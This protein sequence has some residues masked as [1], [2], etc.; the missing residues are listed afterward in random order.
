MTSAQHDTTA[1]YRRRICR[2]IDFL[3]AHLDEAPS[4]AQIAK[5]APF[6]SFHFQRLFR[7]MLGE[8]VGEF[9]RRLRLEKAA[10][11]LLFSPGDDITSIAIDLGFSSSQN[12]A[13][14]F[15]KHFDVS[16]TEY[17]SQQQILSKETGEPNWTDVSSTMVG[18]V[19][20]VRLPE[21]RVVYIRHF[22][23]YNDAG[24][25][26][27]FESLTR[28][29]KQRGLDEWTH[30]LGVPW[31]DLD[32]SSEERCRF[33]ACLTVGEQTHVGPQINHQVLPAGQYATYHCEITN[34]DFELPWTR[35]MR[36]W[37]PGSGYQPA[38]GPRLEFYH[39]DGSD[40][41]QG[42]WDLEVALPVETL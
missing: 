19:S 36:D 3:N 7:A 4:V 34:H 21:R 8:S 33:D 31:D 2:A 5:A 40:D 6:S 17:R 35:L 11:R 13:K 38:D 16:P 23:S 42:R 37:L 25:Q 22:G 32:V 26:G 18:D 14:A 1:E 30:Y 27:A 39:S 10:R 12:F 41:E 15:K 24:V 9:T 29:A 20:V 28:W